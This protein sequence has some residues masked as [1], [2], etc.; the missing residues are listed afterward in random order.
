[1]ERM[2]EG[3]SLETSQQRRLDAVQDFH[4][5]RREERMEKRDLKR[6]LMEDFLSGEKSKRDIL[7]I[8]DEKKEKHL[9]N[10][11]EGAELW[12]D[13]LESLGDDQKDVLFDNMQ[14]LKE[15]HK[16]RKQR[17]KQKRRNRE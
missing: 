10:K 1:M 2:F 16:E 8:M 5:E 15:E 6:T 3:I 7:S 13:L 9:S 17:R 4:S 12:M 11:I 14:D